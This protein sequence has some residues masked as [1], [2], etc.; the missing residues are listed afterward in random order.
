MHGPK[1]IRLSHCRKIYALLSLK[2]MT[3]FSITK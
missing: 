3:A 1:N 2:S